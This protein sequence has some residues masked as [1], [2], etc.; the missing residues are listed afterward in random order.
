MATIPNRES[1]GFSTSEHHFHDAGGT[2]GAIDVVQLVFASG[3]NVQL[4]SGV[5]A[6]LALTFSQGLEIDLGVLL[7]NFDY[8]VFEIDHGVT[9]DLDRVIGAREFDFVRFVSFS[10]GSNGL[11]SRGNNNAPA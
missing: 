8:R 2:Q 10:H 5:L 1:R 3:N 4:H 9:D 11:V 6:F 7:Q